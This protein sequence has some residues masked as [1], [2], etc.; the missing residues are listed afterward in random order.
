MHELI[1]LPGRPF[2]EKIA[3]YNKTFKENPRSVTMQDILKY[4]KL[5]GKA[6]HAELGKAQV[7]LCTCGS[8]GNGLFKKAFY[9]N[10]QQVISHNVP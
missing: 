9:S 7:I 5:L 3:K 10:V 4:K 1:R 2:A 6:Y 8:S